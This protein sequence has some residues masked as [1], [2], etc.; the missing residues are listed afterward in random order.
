VS[1]VE[2]PESPGDLRFEIRNIAGRV[3]AAMTIEVR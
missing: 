2:R 3:R 1:R